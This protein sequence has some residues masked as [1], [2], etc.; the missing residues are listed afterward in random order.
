MD[1]N[2]DV[3]FEKLINGQVIYQSSNLGFNLL[4]SR[5][6]KKFKLNETKSEMQSC[7]NEITAF[8]EKYKTIMAK[9][10]E[11]IKSL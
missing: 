4:I 5:L 1:L 7:I 8:C 2:L 3:K 11:K 9:D 6:Q 10:L